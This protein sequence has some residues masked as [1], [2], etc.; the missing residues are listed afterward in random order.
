MKPIPLY[1][2]AGIDNAARRDDFLKQ[3]RENI[4]AAAEFGWKRVITLAGD[5]AASATRTAWPTACPC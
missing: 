2:L 1:P 4:A 3:F 5:R